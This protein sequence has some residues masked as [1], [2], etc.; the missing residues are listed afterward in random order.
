MFLQNTGIYLQVYTA[1][2]PRRTSSLCGS[3][4][5]KSRITTAE[6]KFKRQTA[7]CIEKDCKRI[8][9]L[10]QPNTDTELTNILNY[11]KKLFAL[12][13]WGGGILQ[14][15]YEVQIDRNNKPLAYVE[16]I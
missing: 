1:S 4:T 14:I 7:R 15:N 13:L 3:E 8:N 11:R 6:I 2:E 12:T 10:D 9:I 5:N 16:E